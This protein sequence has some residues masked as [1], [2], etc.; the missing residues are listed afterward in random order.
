MLALIDTRITKLSEKHEQIHIY[1]VITAQNTN[2]GTVPK[3]E[4]SWQTS[5]PRN[6]GEKVKRDV[7]AQ[8]VLYE[9]VSRLIG[10]QCYVT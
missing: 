3:R 4:S 7:L 10:K 6:F 9:I 2:I 8:K 5:L 1:R